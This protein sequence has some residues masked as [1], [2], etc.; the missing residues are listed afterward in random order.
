MKP[1][2]AGY[3]IIKRVM[4]LIGGLL[5]T[6]IT[7]VIY[8]PLAILIKFDSRGPV[9]FAQE[10]VGKNE[11]VFQIYKFRTMILSSSGQGPKPDQDDERVTRLGRFLRRSSLD[12]IPQFFNVLRGDMSLVGPR[13]EQLVFAATFREWQK[14]RFTVKPGLTGW[15]QVNGRKQPMSDHID[16]DIFY[17]DHQSIGLDL[18]ILLRTAGA[19]ISGKG[20]V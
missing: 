16:E 5:G 18:K 4:D 3:E 19:V 14:R 6:L 15:W 1:D 12:E 13:P 9:I 17:V 20:A 11:Q 8:L 7:G 2:R 10:R